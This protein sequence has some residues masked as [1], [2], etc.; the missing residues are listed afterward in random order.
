[1]TVCPGLDHNALQLWFAMSEIFKEL[2]GGL[3]W[4]WWG[5]CHKTCC[6][7]GPRGD[8]LSLLSCLTVA[9]LAG[10]DLERLGVEKVGEEEASCAC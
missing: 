10:S 8:G 9:T 2:G 6:T 5:F 1:M 3:W 7:S 4:G